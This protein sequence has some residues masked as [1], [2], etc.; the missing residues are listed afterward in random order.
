M[1]HTHKYVYVRADTT[2]SLRLYHR[3]EN[4][5]GFSPYHVGITQ[6]NYNHGEIILLIL[7]VPQ[8]RW[9]F[10][11]HPPI[12]RIQ[13]WLD[14]QISI[15]KTTLCGNIGST[16]TIMVQPTFDVIRKSTHACE[17]AISNFRPQ[18]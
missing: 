6:R 10:Q 18:I 9:A 1:L 15:S 16:S 13:C 5:K 7:V 14:A 4:K 17:F 8:S 11:H 3:Q 12:G 2:R